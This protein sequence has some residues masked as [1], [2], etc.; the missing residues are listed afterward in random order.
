VEAERQVI[1]DAD[2]REGIRRLWRLLD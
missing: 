2:I 1:E